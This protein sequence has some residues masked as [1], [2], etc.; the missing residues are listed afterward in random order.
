M[1][2]QDA[3]ANRS[4]YELHTISTPHTLLVNNQWRYKPMLLTKWKKTTENI[5]KHEH[6]NLW[7]VRIYQLRDTKICSQFLAWRFRHLPSW[8]VAFFSSMLHFQEPFIVHSIVHFCHCRYTLKY[9]EIFWIEWH[10]WFLQRFL[11]LSYDSIMWFR[12]LLV[13]IPVIMRFSKDI[14]QFSIALRCPV[15]TR[16]PFGLPVTTEHP[17]PNIFLLAAHTANSDASRPH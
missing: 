1:D 7:S 4:W 3:T 14:T 17:A 15:T 9:K 5:A 16:V 10:S 6:C 11:T 8:N 12:R 13:L 2:V